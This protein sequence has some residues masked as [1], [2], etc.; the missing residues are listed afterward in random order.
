[1]REPK[2]WA[3]FNEMA[4]GN[5]DIILFVQTQGIPPSLKL[6]GEFYLPQHV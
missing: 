1:M 5:G 2:R 3:E 6:V 4:N